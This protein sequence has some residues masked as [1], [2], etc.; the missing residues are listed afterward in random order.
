MIRRNRKFNKFSVIVYIAVRGSSTDMSKC[1][2]ENYH[3]LQ[4]LGQKKSATISKLIIEQAPK[5][6]VK[7]ISE[8]CY[9][10]VNNN[11]IPLNL[12]TENYLKRKTKLI[13]RLASKQLPIGE[14]KKILQNQPPIFLATILPPCLKFLRSILEN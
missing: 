11:I 3:L 2:S 6:L 9:N 5:S 7:A 10:L 4:V 13:H 8:I 1:L 12:P 14:K